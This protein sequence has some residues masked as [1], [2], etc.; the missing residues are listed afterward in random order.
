MTDALGTPLWVD[1]VNLDTEKN[2][3]VWALGLTDI[4]IDAFVGN[5]QCHGVMR[6]IGR[7]SPTDP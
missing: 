2:G 6:S 3:L 4:A 7:L 5:R 1:L